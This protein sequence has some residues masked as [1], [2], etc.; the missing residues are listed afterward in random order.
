MSLSGVKWS[1]MYYVVLERFNMWE[2]YVSHIVNNYY[3]P[4]KKHTQVY[5]CLE[6][7]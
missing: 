4:I 6:F 5:R 3:Q 2:M 7:N 1:S